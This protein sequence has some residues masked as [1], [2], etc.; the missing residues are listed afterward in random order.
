MKTLFTIL[1]LSAFSIF[2]QAQTKED[3][4]NVIQ[5]CI[6]IK[7][8]QAYYHSTI[9]DSKPVLVILEND[10][11]ESLNLKQF[12]NPVKHFDMESLFAFNYK[13][14]LKFVRISIKGNKADILLQYEI[15]NIKAHIQ[16]EKKDG[17][18]LIKSQTIKK[19]S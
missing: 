6:D 9:I 13:A 12:G 10:K 17:K 15:E 19:V 11:T 4:Q 7:D 5:Q 16:L 2:T 18:W 1:I 3:K 14:F 8:L